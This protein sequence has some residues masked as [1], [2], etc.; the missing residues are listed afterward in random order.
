MFNIPLLSYYH[1]LY[2]CNIYILDLEWVQ[3]LVVPSVLNDDITNTYLYSRQM[4]VTFLLQ[5]LVF[6]APFIF[7]S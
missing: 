2:Y 7:L 5:L 3:F 1:V 6:V 4:I